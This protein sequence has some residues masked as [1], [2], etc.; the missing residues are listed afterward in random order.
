MAH[1]S[2]FERLISPVPCAGSN[3]AAK[4]AKHFSRMGP[5]VTCY[6]VDGGD[7]EAIESDQVSGKREAL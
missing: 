3:Q 7:A 5:C 4:S 6:V 1:E 2:A